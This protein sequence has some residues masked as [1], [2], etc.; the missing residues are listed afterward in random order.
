MSG[1]A[2][3]IS[4]ERRMDDHQALD[5]GG[6][7]VFEQPYDRTDEVGC[8]VDA[9]Q[10]QATGDELSRIEGDR[11]RPEADRSGGHHLAADAGLRRSRR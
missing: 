4:F 7:A 11:R 6:L 10:P 5:A 3:S 9:R 1:K 8:G 2:A